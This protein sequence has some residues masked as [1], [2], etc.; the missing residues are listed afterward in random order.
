MPYNHAM[1]LY[2]AERWPLERHEERV[3]E[4]EL[5]ARLLPAQ[6]R[7][8]WSVWLAARLRGVADRL[9]GHAGPDAAGPVV[10]RLTKPS[11]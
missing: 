2:T 10:I 9:D 4:A 5:R 6:P 7:T 11:L 8:A 3:R 1:D